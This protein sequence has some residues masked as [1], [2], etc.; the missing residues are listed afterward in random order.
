MTRNDVSEDGSSTSLNRRDPLQKV[1]GAGVAVAGGA[2]GV[3]TAHRSNKMA[4]GKV[5]AQIQKDSEA[6]A[7]IKHAKQ[8][9][10]LSPNFESLSVIHQ[11]VTILDSD[12]KRAELKFGLSK[13]EFDGAV[14]PFESPKDQNL[15]ENEWVLTWN[16]VEITSE[17]LR[18]QY[19][20]V[21][22]HHVTFDDES[23]SMRSDSY[24]VRNGEIRSTSHTSDAEVRPL[25]NDSV[26]TQ[27]SCTNNFTLYCTETP[28]IS[29]ILGYLAN[30]VA[31]G[32]CL[33]GNVLSCLGCALSSGSINLG[34]CNILN[35]CA[36]VC[37]TDYVEPD[38]DG[39]VPN[40][41]TY[42]CRS[43]NPVTG[44]CDSPY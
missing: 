28:S 44:V 29:C 22:L 33:L 8:K 13:S 6:K 27:T 23:N 38:D 39:Y 34:V 5:I 43:Y 19:H 10:G 9:A 16:N 1:G 30:S 31:C 21:Q 12:D 7:L 14:V 40:D 24:Y 18:D 3:A 25:T 42:R 15:P 20:R 17:S 32:G 4:K 11:D 36:V 41:S 37:P 26:T 2:T 35:Y